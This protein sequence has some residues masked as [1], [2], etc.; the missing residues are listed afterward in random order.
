MK[1]S[2]N[3][4]QNFMSILK[5]QR[6]QEIKITTE[7]GHSYVPRSKWDQVEGNFYVWIEDKGINYPQECLTQENYIKKYYKNMEVK[8]C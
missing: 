8:G 4:A 5:M 6:S 2:G 1:L 7:A 3:R